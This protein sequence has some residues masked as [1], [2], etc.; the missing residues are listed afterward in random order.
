MSGL[1]EQLDLRVLP[2]PMR[3]VVGFMLAFGVVGGVVG[4]ILGLWANP[5][6]AWFAVAEVGMP[7]AILGMLVGLLAGAVAFVVGRLRTH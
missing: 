7:S 2:V 3:F 6:T 1:R 4:L 5:A